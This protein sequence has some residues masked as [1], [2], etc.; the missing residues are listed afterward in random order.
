MKRT[1]LIGRRPLSPCRVQKTAGCTLPRLL[2]PRIVPRFSEM[3]PDLAGSGTLPYA[4]FSARI[5]F[6]S[7]QR[8]PKPKS[9]CS[10]QA[11]ATGIACLGGRSAPSKEHQNINSSS[12]MPLLYSVGLT[13]CVAA[14][15]GTKGHTNDTQTHTHQEDGTRCQALASDSLRSSTVV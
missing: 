7:Q 12:S 3:Y 1:Q 10:K 2:F 9:S 15:R 5:N 11:M 14:E 6:C 13:E 4:I 8:T